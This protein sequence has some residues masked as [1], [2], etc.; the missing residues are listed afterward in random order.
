MED[1]LETDYHPSMSLYATP[2]SYAATLN[3]LNLLMTIAFVVE[4]VVNVVAQGFI[5]GP[6]TYLT[7]SWNQVD[8]LVVLFGVV[9]IATSGQGPNLKGLRSAKVGRVMLYAIRRIPDVR[10]L[11]ELLGRIL[12]RL[13]A[14]LVFNLSL[15]LLFALLYQQVFMNVGGSR[16]HE[17]NLG[18][19]SEVRRSCSPEQTQAYGLNTCQGPVGPPN[20]TCSYCEPPSSKELS[21]LSTDDRAQILTDFA[22]GKAC[23]LQDHS[24]KPSHNPLLLKACQPHFASVLE[25]TV[26]TPVTERLVSFDD[27]ASALKTTIQILSLTGWG[28]IMQD[29][30]DSDQALNSIALMFFVIVGPLFSLKSVLAVIAN[31]LNVL[32]EKEDELKMRNVVRHWKCSYGSSRAS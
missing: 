25:S 9:E 28:N 13:A 21:K 22:Q 14:A 10:I 26:G 18:L 27:Y 3:D 5:W 2:T 12:E 23:D 11:V 6:R 17:V 32:R 19:P 30:I 4:C 8:F 31:K 16:C 20:R 24:K 29:S 15:V 1:P 7:D